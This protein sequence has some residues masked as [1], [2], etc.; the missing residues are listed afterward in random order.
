MGNNDN[1]GESWFHSTGEGHKCLTH[2]HQ[3]WHKSPFSQQINLLQNSS[4]LQQLQHLRFDKDRL[5]GEVMA[6]RETKYENEGLI[7][8]QA[9][10]IRDMKVS[11]FRN[12]VF[13]KRRWTF[14]KCKFTLLNT[15]FYSTSL[16]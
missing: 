2:T 9:T 13:H 11:M 5:E 6:L 1:S 10:D 3:N 14:G 12:Q 16:T 7:E 4:L 8:S 15:A